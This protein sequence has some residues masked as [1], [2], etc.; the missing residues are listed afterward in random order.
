MDP[1]I[2]T[3][4]C[5]RLQTLHASVRRGH[6]KQRAQ[7]T[8]TTCGYCEYCWNGDGDLLT[9]LT[10]ARVRTCVTTT[11]QVHMGRMPTLLTLHALHGPHAY[12][13]QTKVNQRSAQYVFTKV[14]PYM[15]T[16]DFQRQHA[17]TT[18]QRLHADTL[19]YYL[20]TPVATRWPLT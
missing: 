20:Q 4:T 10:K 17:G 12:P 9:P 13:T 5:T 7:C 2:R 1:Y 11:A 18:I 3:P 8:N 16:D 14:N 15:I 6:K 19:K